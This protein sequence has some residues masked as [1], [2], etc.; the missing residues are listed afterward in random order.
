MSEEDIINFF[1]NIILKQL[2]LMI[3]KVKFGSICSGGI[4]S[5]LQTAM[6]N[7]INKNFI[8]GTLHHQ[9]KD[10]ITE[11]LS[12]FENKLKKKIYKLNVSVKS[13]KKIVSKCTKN[14]G[15][16]YLT[17]DFIGRYQISNFF[18][19]KKIAK[20]FLWVMV[21]TNFLGATSIIEK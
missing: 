11:N 20:Y 9:Q 3:P 13:N 10:K 19:K 15:I 5:S 2:K 14:I 17:H 16:P 1:H 7:T 6:I 21:Q 12:G 4:D 8:I 18:K